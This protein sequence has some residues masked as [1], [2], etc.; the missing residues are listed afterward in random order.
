MNNPDTFKEFIAYSK[1]DNY[2]YNFS[3]YILLKG[4][5]IVIETTDLDND[6]KSKNKF[7]NEL[8]LKDWQ[9]LN[10]DLH[11]FDNINQ[12]FSLFDNI[13]NKDFSIIKDNN[14]TKLKMIL[15]DKW[16]RYPVTIILNEYKDIKNNNN[17]I[18]ENVIIQNDKDYLEKKIEMLEDE[19]NKIKLSIPFNLFDNTLYVLEKVYNELDSTEIISNRKYLGLINSGIK[20]IFD[21]NIKAFHLEYNFAKGNKQNLY[22]FS[23]KC[24]KLE[25][26]LIVI[27]TM[28]NT[29]FGAFFKKNNSR[30][31]YGAVSFGMSNYCMHNFNSK[32]YNNNNSFIFS[33]DK[34]R[35]YYNDL[36]YK[37]SCEEPYFSIYYDENNKCFKGK[38]YKSELSF[39]RNTVASSNCSTYSTNNNSTQNFQNNA[40]SKKQY[41]RKDDCQNKKI[42]NVQLYNM[43]NAPAVNPIKT[44]TKIQPIMLEKLTTRNSPYQ[45][46]MQENYS[47]NLSNE[48]QSNPAPHP[49]TEHVFEKKNNFIL[50]GTKEFIVSN[51]EIFDLDF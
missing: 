1:D 47:Y 27:K 30:N 25:N 34:M 36:F 28:N 11:S 2:N 9:K 6:T 42:S 46:Q 29:T 4:D 18:E 51:L 19:I 40:Q 39:P 13:Q 3:I 49:I 12:I 37:D 45:S 23:E 21:K 14:K 15:E 20:K 38:E 7:I 24:Q 41:M 48:N 17:I 43:G 5:T 44:H 26:L 31:F 8:L 33:L 50:S 10:K 22:Q 16:H 32:D 35:I